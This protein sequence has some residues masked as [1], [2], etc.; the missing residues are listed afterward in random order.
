M[1]QCDYFLFIMHLFVNIDTGCSWLE[2]FNE[3]L[4]RYLVLWLFKEYWVIM[5]TVSVKKWKNV[6]CK[7]HKHNVICFMQSFTEDSQGDNAIDRINCK[8]SVRY[9][10]FIFLHTIPRTI[11]SSTIWNTKDDF[12][13]FNHIGNS[14]ASALKQIIIEMS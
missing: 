1:L 2:P 14:L 6:T 12:D 4:V 9:S 7:Q 5:S 10:I 3:L 8:I 13:Y 11:I